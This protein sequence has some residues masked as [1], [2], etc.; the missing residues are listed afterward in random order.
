MGWATAGS[1]SSPAPPSSRNGRS[2]PSPAAAFDRAV[3]KKLRGKLTEDFLDGL[4]RAH[5][6]KVKAALDRLHQVAAVDE[7]EAARLESEIA[8]LVSALA[9]GTAAPDITGAIA[10]RRTKVEALR[11]RPAVPTFT[12]EERE[13]H[14]RLMIQAHRKCFEQADHQNAVG[15]PVA[16]RQALRA[17]GVE[18]VV[19][20]PDG[21]GWTFDI[22]ADFGRFVCPPTPATTAR[23]APSETSP[24]IRHGGKAAVRTEGT[25]TPC[26]RRQSPGRRGT[27]TGA[28]AGTRAA[29][30][31]PTLRQIPTSP[32]G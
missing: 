17:L 6:A 8:R 27:S 32:A 3:R 13:R 31:P 28:R 19:A 5:E 10:E 2:G 23:S 30:R 26:E 25:R 9:A 29:R 12:R 15:D 22:K 18:H 4:W 7:K 16:G 24:R 1:R 20:K 14:S 21:D 11:A